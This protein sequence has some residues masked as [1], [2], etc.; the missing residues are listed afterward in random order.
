MP[1]RPEEEVL[2]LFPEKY[3]PL[4]QPYRYKVFYGGRGGAKSWSFAK[5]LVIKSYEQPLR[6]LCTREYQ[7]SIADSVHRLISDQITALGLSPWFNITKAS[8]TSAAG[9]Q[10]IFKGLQRSIQEIKSTEG[11]DIAWVEEAQAISE[12]SWE[13]LIPTVRKDG[14]EIWISFNPDE[15]TDPTYQRFVKNTPPDTIIQK[16]NW[17]DNPYFPEVLNRERL[18]MLKVDPEGYQHVW[19]G[20][21][22]QVTDAIILKGHYEVRTFDPPPEGTRLYYGADWGFSQDPTV[23]VRC[24]IQDNYLYV[25][26]ETYGVGIELD[27][28]PERFETVPGAKQWP[29]KAD[30]SRPET[31]SHVRRRGF[32]ISG[33]KKWSG[34]VEDGIAILKGFRKIIVHE[35]CKHTAEEC[36]LYSYKVD[37]QTN[38]ILPTILDKNN[39]CIDAIR[40]ALVDIIRSSNLFDGCDLT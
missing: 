7:N 4:F 27:D 6:I 8:I 37:K 22:R 19:E 39:H 33:A 10:F 1:E 16:V 34:S 14:S 24:W 2:T 13:I 11:I 25:D 28:I 36:R 17:D 21:C 9:S 32:K 23:L 18:Y 30:S 20:F 29:I 3:E 26:Y 35:R 15:E 12:D 31:I 5:A 38:E 40:Y